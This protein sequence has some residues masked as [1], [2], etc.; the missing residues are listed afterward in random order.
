MI[1][2]MPPLN[3]A[4]KKVYDYYQLEFMPNGYPGRR[5]EEGII[6]HPIYGTYVISDYL[7]QYRRTGDDSLLAGIHRVSDA[8]RE[9]MT[10]IE[11]GLL[12]FYPPGISG[13]DES[14]ASGLTQSRYMD[15]FTRVYQKTKDKK[16]K[17]L[18]DA[19]FRSHLV[20][21]EKGGPLLRWNGETIIEEYPFRIPTFVQNGWTT[22]LHLLKQYAD[23]FKND[24]AQELFQDSLKSLIDFLPKYDAQSVSSS[25]YELTR[26]VVLQLTKRSDGLLTLKRG[27]VRIGEQEFLIDPS[28]TEGGSRFH[29]RALAGATNR[30]GIFV[31]NP[32]QINLLL[33]RASY[34]DP[35][36][37]TLDLESSRTCL[38]DIEVSHGDFSNSVFAG[39]HKMEWWDHVQTVA[40]HKGH[41]TI[42][43]PVPWDKI[44][45]VG[46]PTNFGKLIGG[47]SYNVYHF[48]HIDNL[49]RLNNANP[50]PE[51]AYWANRWESYAEHWPTH[52]IYSELD[53][54]YGRLSEDRDS[55][56]SSKIR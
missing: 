31:K 49:N 51:L 41:N 29:N 22:S 17:E 52:R 26:P 47:R 43:F 30:N 14:F 55:A 8:A 36:I 46:H 35:N 10:E 27:S 54:S 56:Q 7:A 4:R 38:V 11:G 45:L 48:I 25:R 12:F 33:S 16:F 34:P 37:V 40:L 18:A 23:H 39:N 44:P 24:V 3:P 28:P 50:H 42:A 21:V 19:V 13:Y 32:A 5:T 2:K 9:Q 20:S 1:H 6:P 53:V 15:V